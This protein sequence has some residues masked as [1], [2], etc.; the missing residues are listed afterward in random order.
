MAEWRAAN[1]ETLKRKAKEYYLQNKNARI[2]YQKTYTA[3][4]A[5]EIAKYQKEYRERNPK[6]MCMIQKAFRN[7]PDNK[8]KKLRSKYNLTNEQYQNY[9]DTNN[10]EICGKVFA[11]GKDKHID[12]CHKSGKVSYVEVVITVLATLATV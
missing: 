1:K 2:E 12:H 4:H 11:C 9:L 3:E 10:C 6:K 8:E 7:K 5:D